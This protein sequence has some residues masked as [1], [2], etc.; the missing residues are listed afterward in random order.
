MPRE[1]IIQIYRSS[2][3]ANVPTGLTAGEVAA[4]LIDRKMFVGGTNGSIITFLDASAVVT[5]VNGVTG[6]VTN[7]AVTNANN[8]FTATQTF[9][10][11]VSA[12]WVSV[13]GGLTAGGAVSI[14]ALGS[15][16]NFLNSSS[17]TGKLRISA[18]STL[19]A[20][21]RQ[22][23][24]QL[25]DADADLGGLANI[26]VDPGAGV[27]AL[28]GLGTTGAVSSTIVSYGKMSVIG[29]L[30]AQSLTVAAGATFSSRVTFSGGI[31]T[32]NLWVGGQGATFNSNATF[33]NAVSILGSL[34][35]QSLF[36]AQGVTFNSTSTHTGLATFNAGITTS[37]TW[38]GGNGATFSSRASAVGGLTATDLWVGGGGATFNSA[39]SFGAGTTF[40]GTAFH[41]SS[42][43]FQNAEYIRN[44]TDG[45]MDFMPSPNASTAFGLYMDMTSWTYGVV[46]GTI[47]T[48]D[49][50][51]NTGGNF[52]FDV[53]LTINNDT[54]FQLGSD[55]Q[56]RFL[57]TNTGNDTA[58]FG[59]YCDGVN[60]SGAFA[61][62]GYGSEQLANRSPTTKHANPNVYIYRDGSANPGDFMRMEHDGSVGRIASGAT[63]GIELS[64]GRGT[65]SISGGISA[66][67]YVL[68]S[69]GIQTKTTAYSLTG[70]D[71]G[72]VI[73]FN[74]AGGITANIPAG[75]PIGFSV[76]LIQVGAGQVTVTGPAG[77]A[78]ITMNSY[79]NLYKIAGQHGSA[80]LVSYQ[81]NVF[82][83]AGNLA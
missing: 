41:A 3:A 6:A 79:T 1:S 83:L 73:I 13:R 16:D 40:G 28:V 50:A 23:T 58:Q 7:V 14:A 21:S 17:S 78:G 39:V 62:V 68:S 48:S 9:N 4:N 74:A 15:T 66:D 67:S 42:V 35:A 19:A 8:N 26:Y 34:T 43:A 12:D 57:R 70:S 29:G 44:T 69:N 10:N 65:V 71:N 82:N 61:F 33:N 36:V 63:S 76:T 55:G 18:V 46:M 20:T 75:L 2:T 45:Q 51:K 52:R 47:R 80:S 49:M 53:P 38:I 64:P 22:P 60:N 54:F 24:I 27:G 30:S 59:A 56:Y 72:K 5:G 77:A 81:T 37:S 32:S 11:G 31:T 25:I